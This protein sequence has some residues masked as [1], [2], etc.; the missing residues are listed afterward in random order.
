M[1][2]SQ[3][4]ESHVPADAAVRHPVK[5]VIDGQDCIVSSAGPHELLGQ[6]L[7]RFIT[8]DE[9]RY[10][11]ELLLARVRTTGVEAVVPFRCDTP[12]ARRY[13]TVR[14]APGPRE[15]D[16]AFTIDTYR[17]EPR[18]SERLLDA[19]TPR[20]DD[21]L[22]ICSW[23]KRVRVDEEWLEVEEAVVRLRLLE[24]P[25]LPALTHGACVPCVT[26]L[27]ASLGLPTPDASA[28]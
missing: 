20:S 28:D 7:W 25:L 5:Y 16:V 17:H 1:G 22:T 18:R 2:L 26:S 10:I 27:R 12:D 9:T 14:L 6:P 19:G 24:A 8:D 15:G 4:H 21:L 3:M 13:M 23:C 11:Y